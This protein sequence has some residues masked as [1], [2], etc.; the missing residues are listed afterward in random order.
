MHRL[1]L[2]IGFC[3]LALPLAAQLPCRTAEMMDKWFSLH[4]EYKTAYEENQRHA[5]QLDSAA[6]ASGYNK[7]AK[8]AAPAYTIP[9]VFHILHQ[10][11]PE[12]ISDAQIL[13]AVAILNR[14]YRKKNADTASISPSFQSLA[15]DVNFEFALATL[16]PSGNCTNGIVRHYDSRTNWNGDMSDYVYTWPHQKYLN[17]YVVKSMGN[18]AAGYTYLPGTVSA[19]MDVIVILNDYVGSIGTSNAYTS[20][21]LTHEV[22]HWFNLQHTWGMTNQPGVA[23]GDDGVSDTPVTKGFYGCW[24]TNP[25]VCNPPIVENI[26]NYMEY[27]YCSKMFTTGQATRMN[28]CIVS[29]VGQ[30]NNVASAANLSATGVDF[31][32]GPC[33]PVAD[34]MAQNT[35]GCIGTAFNFLD[36]SYNG[37]VTAWQWTFTNGSPTVSTAQNP[38]ASFT[39]AGLKPVTLK[40]SNSFGSD[41]VIKSL[42]LVLPG[43]G[44]GTPAIVQSFETIVFP[45]TNWMCVPPALGSGWTQVSGNGASGNKCLYINNYFDTPNKPV[46]FYSPMYNLSG[47]PGPV[48]SFKVAYSSKP[49]GCNDRLRVYASSDCAGSWQTIYSKADTTL[50]TYGPGGATA[51]GAFSNPTASQ[52]RK[53]VVSLSAYSSANNLLLKF[54]FSPDSSNPGNNIFLDDINI[55]STTGIAEGHTS[56]FPMELYPNPAHEQVNLRITLAKKQ[57]ITFEILDVTGRAIQTVNRNTEAGSSQHTFDLTHL[58]KG[59]YFI[60][61]SG[62]NFVGLRRVV[63][64]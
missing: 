64:E 31:P 53:E 19:N 57:E 9:V 13:D 50:N 40:A 32:A 21:A 62:E 63:V 11:G 18:G 25:A 34:F 6:V 27:A 7:T 47:L 55:E 17:V 15:A 24:N 39:S 23:C 48:L 59:L 29:P 4:P 16:D 61:A 56:I 46:S 51:S 42:V 26:Q 45:D 52:W 12:N 1:L 10:N 14:D 22:G 5:Y 37:T 43:P 3:L 8:T 28:N 36:L 54:E 41:S 20:R 2:Q 35:E 38:A 33:A 58:A 44:S 49:G 30:R 60:R